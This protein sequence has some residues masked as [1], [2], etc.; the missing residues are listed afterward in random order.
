MGAESDSASV[1]QGRTTANLSVRGLRYQQHGRVFY[2]TVLTAQQL[3]GWTE[4]PRYNPMTKEGYQRDVTERRANKAA[5]YLLDGGVF[6]GAVILSLREDERKGVKVNVVREHAGYD[7]VELVIPSGVH[8]LKLVDGQHRDRALSIAKDRK[9][10]FPSEK[11]GL[12]TVI[13]ESQ[14]EIDEAL[15]FRTIHSEQRNVPTDLTNRLLQREVEEGHSPPE[16]LLETGQ[17]GKYRDYVAV[18]VMDGLAKDDDS[19]WKGLVRPP[20]PGQLPQSEDGEEPSWSVSETSMASS[21]K[22]FVRYMQLAPVERTVGIVKTYW[23]AV[24]K[25]CPEAWNSPDDYPYLQKTPGIYILN[26]LLPSIYERVRERGNVTE[27]TF[28]EVLAEI[29]IESAFFGTN[30]R[31]RGI[32][33]LGGF[34]VVVDDL[35]AKLVRATP[36]K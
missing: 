35:E 11:F 34:K 33:G 9:N 17:K 19:P 27:E 18:K 8:L 32:G 21:L 12:A 31:L 26:M 25:E 23:R 2:S 28:G 30:G 36:S 24:V 14:G 6:P 1:S 15:L 5:E 4:V 16:A 7:E 22:E 13:I 29:G 10:D 3:S 20:N